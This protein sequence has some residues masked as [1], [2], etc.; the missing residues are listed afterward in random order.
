VEDTVLYASLPMLLGLGPELPDELPRPAPATG[1]PAWRVLGLPDE[2]W[3]G[4]DPID[5]QVI[6]AED[7]AAQCSAVQGPWR[8]AFARGAS[9]GGLI[10][11]AES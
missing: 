11:R 3:A 2:D 4:V 6:S 7:C 10:V 1:V 5:A 8:A 9:E